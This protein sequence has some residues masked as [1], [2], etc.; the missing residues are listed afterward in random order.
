MP[1]YGSILRGQTEDQ[2]YEG[3]EANKQRRLQERVVQTLLKGYGLRSTRARKYFKSA[4]ATQDWRFTLEWFNNHANYPVKFVAEKLYKWD[5]IKEFQAFRSNSS[6]QFEKSPAVKRIMDLQDTYPDWPVAFCTTFKEVN[7][8][9]VLYSGPG[10][11]MCDETWRLQRMIG[12]CQYTWTTLTHLA[13]WNM[14]VWDPMAHMGYEERDDE[15]E[16]DI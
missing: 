4:A 13:T 1:D 7:D 16:E 3:L 2:F 8:V 11:S 12:E 15:E 6:K 10:Y 9:L 14:D 5:F